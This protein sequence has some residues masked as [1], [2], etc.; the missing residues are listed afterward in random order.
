MFSG[1]SS[2][3]LRPRARTGYDRAVRALVTGATGFIG[4]SLTRAL[5]E[6]GDHVTCLVRPTSNRSALEALGVDFALGDVNQPE[7]LA[8]A[9]D[10]GGGH[11][12]VFH[13]AAM[14]TAPWHPDFLR[15]N[16]TGVRN[17][18]EAAAAAKRKPRVVLASSLA[19]V[20]PSAGAPRRE[21][22]PPAPVSRYGA[23]KLAG[24]SAA[25]E[26]ADKVAITMVR[27]PMVF[28]PGD[29]HVLPAFQSATRGLGIDF[30]GTFSMI[31]VDDLAALLRLAADRGE[32]VRRDGGLGAGVYF[33]ADE[34]TPTARELWGLLG[35]VVGRRVRVVPVPRAAIRVAG[36]LAEVAGRLGG[37]SLWSRDKAIEATAG[38]WTC[39]PAKARGLGWA[40]AKGLQDRLADTAAWYRATGALA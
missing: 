17:V 27:P 9:V 18:L 36:V 33:A 38:N 20:G 31:Y 10:S 6:A 15:T 4:R 21:D 11:D 30:G 23:S 29:Q 2:R 28:G 8:A 19:A 26:L 35:G 32:T 14:L 5:V 22:D 25:R 34:Q 7:S 3:R 16:A 40:P 13:L 39:S 24:E 1:A 12:V 37:P